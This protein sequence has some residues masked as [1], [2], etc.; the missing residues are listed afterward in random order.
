[1]RALLW[2][3]ALFA[4]AVGLSLA[5]RYNEGYVMLVLPPYRVELSFT[6]FVVLTAMAFV[7]GYLGLRLA[8]NT[9]SLPAKVQ[10]FRAR[11]QREKATRSFF[12]ALRFNI[13]GRFGHALKQATQAHR[14]GAATGLS[15]LLAARAARA[16]RDDAQEREWLQRAAENDH[17]LYVARLMTELELHLDARRFA[18]ALDVLNTLAASGQRH[19]AAQRLALRVYQAVG[20]WQDLLKVARQL[21]KHQAIS[22][23][24]ASSL[25]QHAHLEN[26][27]ACAGNG[28]S[29]G[30]YW[31]GVPA[32]ERA[33]SRVAAAVVRALFAA[34]DCAAGQRVIEDRLRDSWD[35][36]LVA[37]YADCEGG[38]VLA[39]VTQAEAWLHERPGDA[40]LLLTL[41]RLCKQLQ[42]WGKAQNYLEASIAVQPSAQ[43]HLELARFFD[44]LDRRDEADRHYRAAT[45]RL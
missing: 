42:L 31:S 39:R 9:L 41:G 17:E 32:E 4:L 19:I 18:E 25:K 12:E 3:L 10:E 44:S 34:G 16:M 20:R 23:E 28:A 5:A 36:A 8:I 37:L 35:C 29:V 33:D 14:A 13:E 6:L 40:C 11:R 24:Y 38:D 43:A 22:R 2:L 15:A 30:A 27:Q 7:L 1:M 26:I 21:E 45:D